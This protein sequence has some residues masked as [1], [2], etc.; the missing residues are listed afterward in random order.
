[1]L[2]LVGH[3]SKNKEQL[4]QQLKIFFFINFIFF[5]REKNSLIKG[6]VSRDL[7]GLQM[8]LMNIHYTWVPD[9][10]LVIC[11]FLNFRFHMVLYNQSFEL[12]KLLLMHSAKA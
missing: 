8:I 2:F 6:I 10:P 3:L 4:R 9:V 1:M 5:T 7:E 12:V 11:Y